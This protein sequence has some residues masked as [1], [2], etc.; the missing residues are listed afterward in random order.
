MKNE[1]DDTEM[2]HSPLASDKN[3]QR[4]LSLCL[5]LPTFQLCFDRR[6]HRS[7]RIPAVTTRTRTM[8][9]ATV[10]KGYCNEC[11]AICP[12]GHQC[13]ANDISTL[14]LEVAQ[15]ALLDQATSDL[16]GVLPDEGHVS[17]ETGQQMF[18]HLVDLDLEVHRRLQI[19]ADVLDQWSA[20]GNATMPSKSLSPGDTVGDAWVRLQDQRAWMSDTIM[21]VA[22]IKLNN[23]S[24][25][26]L[27]ADGVVSN[28]KGA[29]K[30]INKR[31]E[32][33]GAI[34]E[35]DNSY[36]TGGLERATILVE[37]TS[38]PLCRPLREPP[39]PG[40][41]RR[42]WNRAVPRS[43]PQSPL[44]RLTRCMC[45]CP[46]NCQPAS[47]GFPKRTDVHSFRHP[48]R[49]QTYQYGPD[50]VVHG[51]MPSLP[52]RGGTDVRRERERLL[53]G[54]LW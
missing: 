30:R 39:A 7:H 23:D 9:R 3:H 48:Q 19:I 42:R 15:V 45:C 28:C 11:D 10:G 27:Y 14:Y 38:S 2:F 4:I 25:N 22:N 13:P 31:L 44:P 5:T 37:V 24:A 32:C 51:G 49:A 47:Q 54:N 17:D 43:S 33:W 20:T 50:Q 6:H 29:I 34:P 18:A 12:I 40:H 41:V 46:P 21:R 8:P 1:D 16:G 36:N 26:L 35:P 53:P 52:R